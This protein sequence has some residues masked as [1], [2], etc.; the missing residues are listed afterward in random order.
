MRTVPGEPSSDRKGG[1]LAFW[2]TLPGILTGV[3]ALITAVVGVIGL[4]KSQSGDGS[5]NGTPAT[6]IATTDIVGT[7]HNRLSGRLS[8]ARGDS[9]DLEQG[10]IGS[11]PTADLTFGPETTPTLRNAGSTFFAPF[12]GVPTRTRCGL[13]L[14]GRHDTSELVAQFEGSWICVST[15]EGNVAAVKIL[16]APGVGSSKLVL[17]FTAWR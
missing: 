12:K 9:A 11:S 15:A 16:S 7:S 8:L 6:V 17:A 4:W 13:A 3:A 2:T 1:F 14:R 10:Q 5:D